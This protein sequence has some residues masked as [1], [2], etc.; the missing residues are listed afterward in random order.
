VGE[1]ARLHLGLEGGPVGLSVA[2]GGG[3]NLIRI[4]L[5]GERG[6]SDVD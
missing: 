2:S 6:M 1:S 4:L 5:M 3:V